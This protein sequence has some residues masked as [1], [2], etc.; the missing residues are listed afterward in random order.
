MWEIFCGGGIPVKKVVRS[1]RI[2]GENRNFAS[3]FVGVR[4]EDVVVVRVDVVWGRAGRIA[5]EI[6]RDGSDRCRSRAPMAQQHVPVSAPLRP[7][8]EQH[9]VSQVTRLSVEKCTIKHKSVKRELVVYQIG[10]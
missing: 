10:F 6:A 7:S 2:F 1:K 3:F 5:T 8:V 4:R 9:D